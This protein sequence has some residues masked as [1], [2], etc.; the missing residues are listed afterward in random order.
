MVFDESRLRVL[1]D[2]DLERELARTLEVA[3]AAAREALLAHAEAQLVAPPRF[4]LDAGRGRLVFT[5]GAETRSSQALG[6]RVYETYPDRTPDHAQ[7]VAV[8]DARDG[9]L[10]GL[11]VGHLLGALRTAALNA[12]ALERLA[13]PGA[14]VLGVLGTGFQARFHALAALAVAPFEDVRIYSRRPENRA[15]FVRWLASHTQ[16]PVEA[17]DSAEEAVHA[18]D[19]LLEVTSARVPVFDPAWLKPG[20]HVNTVGPKLK[21]AHALPLEAACAADLLVSD[22]P[23]Q[24]EA[25][26]SYFLPPEARRR[27]VPLSAL[28]AGE[29]PGRRRA[30]ERTVF[31]S[32]GLAGTEPVVARRLLEALGGGV[33]G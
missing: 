30:D 26:G 1:D 24:L 17:V 21:G 5:A 20:A 27:V 4:A 2:R 18:A 10:L 13:R 6:F 28:V 33:D 29:H 11:V 14:R 8:W 9:R 22:S 19:V 23:A 16:T 12:V 3:L 32:A 31:L 25:Y 15:D 7:L